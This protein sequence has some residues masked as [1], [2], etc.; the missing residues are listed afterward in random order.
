MIKTIFDSLGKLFF[1][2]TIWYLFFSFI[3]W[4]IYIQNWSG[5]SR[6]FFFVLSIGTWGNMINKS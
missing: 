1:A 4:D 5:V 3:Q 6:L 2:I